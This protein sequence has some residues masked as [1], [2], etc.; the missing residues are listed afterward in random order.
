[1][2]AARRLQKHG[3]E[4]NVLCTINAAN[5]G[6]PLDVYRFFRDELDARYVQLIPIVEVETHAHRRPAR[7]RHGAQRAART[8]M[9]TS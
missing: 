7:R 2:A 8:T 5:A 1:M 4:F 3:A 9:A 6:H